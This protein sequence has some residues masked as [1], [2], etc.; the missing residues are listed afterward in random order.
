MHRRARAFA[1]LAACLRACA[2]CRAVA[3]VAA[4]VLAAGR[5]RHAPARADAPATLQLVDQQA[6][7]LAACLDGSAPP[8]Y[9]RKATSA[10]GAKKWYIH[11]MGGD[12]CGYGETWHE[13][14]QVSTRILG[15][16]RRPFPPLLIPYRA[17]HGFTQR[18]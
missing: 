14:T 12:Y 5:A 17:P 13:W 10:A 6:W 2:L 3:P 11:H 8:Y 1:A 16:R 9:V 18:S 4:G 7:P 15:R